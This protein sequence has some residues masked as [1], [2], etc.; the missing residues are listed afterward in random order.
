MK[1]NYMVGIVAVVLSVCLATPY[2]ATANQVNLV[3]GS[4][5]GSMS[6]EQLLSSYEA[7]SVEGRQ[8][9]NDLYLASLG[10]Q[11][12]FYTEYTDRISQMRMS[13]KKY[14]LFSDALEL[15]LLNKQQEYYASCKELTELKSTVVAI[16]KRFGLSVGP[17][18]TELRAEKKSVEKN[19]LAA[20]KS[21]ALLVEELREETSLGN[22]S[23]GYFFAT[24]AKTYDESTIIYRFINNSEAYLQAGYY[25]REYREQEAELRQPIAEPISEEEGVS[26]E[27]SISDKNDLPEGEDGFEEGGAQEDEEPPV[28]EEL[29]D[30]TSQIKSAYIGRFHYEGSEAKTS[31]LLKSNTTKNKSEGFI[32]AGETLSMKLLTKNIDSLTIDIEGDKSIKTFDDLT[33]RFIYDEPLARGNSVEGL[34]K[35]KEKYNFPI[36]IYPTKVNEDGSMIFEYKYVIPYK[37]SQTLHSWSSLRELGQAGDAI[38][39]SRILERIDKPYKIVIKNKED[40]IKTIN[41]DVFERWDNLLNRDLSRYLL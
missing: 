28:E 27:S 30:T 34:S 19:V 21:K 11:G 25:S 12:A 6:V 1:R 23:L 39:N 7:Y 29:V 26:D 13:S 32:S 20:Q 37:T 10:E 5:T 22:D 4:G 31:S 16:K 14:A 15:C 38:D 2:T 36:T 24:G 33:K 3:S 8:I 40:T 35:I 17:E 41:F 9:R 18:E